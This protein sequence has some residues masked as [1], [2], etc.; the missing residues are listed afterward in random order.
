MVHRRDPMRSRRAQILVL[1]AALGLSACAVDTGDADGA[2]G[3]DDVVHDDVAA[4]DE[5][6]AS[7]KCAGTTATRTARIKVLTMNL[8][9]DEDQWERRFALIADEIVRLDPDVLG[10]QEVE[11]SDDQAGR[12]NELVAKRGHARYHVYAKRKSGFLGW[13]TGEGIAI[14]SRWPIVETQHEDIGEKR[15]SQFARV[16]HPSGKFIDFVNTHLDH[17]GGAEG[18]ANRLDQ[19]EQTIG[20]A[21]RTNDCWPTFLTGDMNAPPSSPAMKEFVSAGFVD[22]YLKVH[23]ADTART[24]N[25][26]MIRLAEG[27]FAQSPDRRIDFVMARRAGERTATPV[28]SVVGFKNHDAKGFYPSDHLGVMTT[29]DV[30][31]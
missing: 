5:E 19:A 16:E 12:L 2:Y 23:G 13:F 25:T 3:A 4:A 29:Y 18:A 11:I 8:R 28:A 30:R 7:G 15:V 22:S 9:H 24:G 21:N 31:L 6:L 17:A 27:A 20:L 26:A 10:L 14:F 1:L